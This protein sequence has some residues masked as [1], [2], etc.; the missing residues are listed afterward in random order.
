MKLKGELDA[1]KKSTEVASG[2]HDARVAEEGLLANRRSW[3]AQV[4]AWLVQVKDLL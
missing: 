4:E 3:L 1:L 2:E